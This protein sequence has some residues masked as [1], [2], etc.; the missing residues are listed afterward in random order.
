ML[1]LYSAKIIHNRQLLCLQFLGLVRLVLAGLRSILNPKG[2]FSSWVALS[3]A[4]FQPFS[5]AISIELLSGRLLERYA[6]K[7]LVQLRQR[8]IDLEE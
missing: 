3:L 5:T 6:V 7:F 2:S 8:Q 1:S 4:P